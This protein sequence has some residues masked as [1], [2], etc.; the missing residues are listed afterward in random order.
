VA[1]GTFRHD[2]FF[3]LL[4][5]EIE[6]PPL[7][8]RLQDLRELVDHFL[9]ILAAKSGRPLPGLAPETVADLERRPWYGNVRELRNALEHAMILARGGTILPEHLPPATPPPE[10]LARQDA[11]ASLIQSWT[12]QELRQRP[13]AADLYQRLL[14]LVEPPLLRAVMRQ[15]GGLCAKAARCLGLHRTTLRKK[16]DELGIDAGRDGPV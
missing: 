14:G 7:R 12:D 9:Q 4:T 2:L 5:F 6:I 8:H 1:E 10:G 3:R 16:L 15:H 13:E 11:I